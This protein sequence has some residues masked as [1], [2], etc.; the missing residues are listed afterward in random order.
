[1]AAYALDIPNAS[2]LL[3]RLHNDPALRTVCGFTGELPGFG[4]EVAADSATVRAW[5]NPNRKSKRNPDGPS[6]P[7]ASWTKKHSAE[8]ASGGEWVFGFKAHDI[9]DT[10][11]GFPITMIFTT[12]KRNDSSQF[13]SLLKKAEAR[14]NWFGINEGS[15]VIAD[16]GYDSGE[17]NECAYR[18]GGAPAAGRR[19]SRWHLRH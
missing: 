8:A 13:I 12:A 9:A 11:Y 2:A 5:G 17:N 4:Q 19:A 18:L 6:T 15:A 16:R 1:L 7:D 10:N 14:H 3:R